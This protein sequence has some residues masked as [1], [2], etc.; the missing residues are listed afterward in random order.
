MEDFEDEAEFQRE[1]AL[2]GPDT[3]DRDDDLLQA[4][5]GVDPDEAIREGKTPTIWA[6]GASIRA[7][8]LPLVQKKTSRALSRYECGKPTWRSGKDGCFNLSRTCETSR[9]YCRMG[10]PQPASTEPPQ[11]TSDDTH[12][13]GC[14]ALTAAASGPVAA[15]AGTPLIVDA[16]HHTPSGLERQVLFEQ[17]RQ[18]EERRQAEKE[19]KHEEKEAQAQLRAVQ[20]EVGGRMHSRFTMVLVVIL[21]TLD[22]GASNMRR[23]GSRSGRRLR[24]RSTPSA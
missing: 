14:D 11:S 8:S 22:H 7:C 17:Y 4:G 13:D 16:V 18:D 15:A 19:R 24:R 10:N 9:P 20:E 2:L 1:L 3:H 5:S 21:L 23:P 12:S 6:A